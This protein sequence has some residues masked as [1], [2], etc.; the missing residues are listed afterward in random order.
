MGG[1]VEKHPLLVRCPV[2]GEKGGKRV[3][4]LGGVTKDIRKKC[5]R[6]G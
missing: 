3:S 2:H 1:G 5:R 6:G 4:F